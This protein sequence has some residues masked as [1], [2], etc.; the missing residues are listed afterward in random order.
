MRF[1]LVTTFFGPHRFGGDA[2]YVERL[3]AALLRRGHEVEVFWSRDAFEAVRGRREPLPYAP[4]A[5]LVMHPLSS[6]WPLWGAAVTHQSGGLG[7]YRRSL[8]RR[9]AEG[10]FDV[11][12]LH[13]VSLIGAAELM[14]L[15]VPG[16]V[17][18]MTLHDH[19]LACPLSVRW[20]FDREACPAPACVR[21]T[22]AAG[23]P[24][25]W[26]RLGGGLARGFRS[27]DA[28]IFPSHR[29][30]ADHAERGVVH[31]RAAVLPYFVPDDWRIAAPP[32]GSRDRFL[33]VGRLVKE[34]GLQTLLPLFRLRPHV[35]LDVVGDGP[36]R[37]EL[38]R[39]AAGAGNI[40]FMGAAGADAVRGHLARAR[41]L[42]V[43]SLF[44]ETLGYV[45]LEAWSQAAPALV[46]AAGALPSLVA[47]GGGAVCGSPAAFA[48]HVDRWLQNPD[49]ASRTGLVGWRRAG[50][51]FAEE[52]HMERLLELV[53]RCRRVGRS[54]EPGAG[55]GR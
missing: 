54:T 50:G 37:P 10:R 38:E 9:L 25:Q 18:L 22:L 48:E 51:E 43:P 4:P 42:L 39:L 8:G 40:C 15:R 52:S 55:S 2:A 1:A 26:W 31:P 20:R 28:V 44:P 23:R 27:L 16:A 36:Y 3:A 7:L 14:R 49:E 29:S 32:G 30:M 13:N 46:S 19:W 11:V 33:F 41:G 6:R 45:V 35:G 21:C 24:P 53:D 5:G 47:D 17:R 12:H 34:K